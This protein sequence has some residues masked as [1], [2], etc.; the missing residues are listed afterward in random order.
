M[1]N[2]SHRLIIT[3]VL[4]LLLL[5]GCNAAPTPT[6]EP[7]EPASRFMDF[8]GLTWGMTPDEAIRALE[9]T[10]AQQANSDSLVLHNIRMT[11]FGAENADVYLY[12]GDRNGDGI[13]TLHQVLAVLPYS[14][15]IDAMARQIEAH[16]GIAPELTE[17]EQTDYA[18]NPMTAKLWKWQSEAVHQDIASAY[19]IETILALD[20][21]YHSMLTD[22]VTYII[23]NNDDIRDHTLDGMHTKNVLTMT[24][25]ISFYQFEGGYSTQ[26]E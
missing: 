4:S 11:V 10:D 20:E 9:L 23:L 21:Q 13:H 6:T 17:K 2:G 14:T 3:L 16:Y 1:K 7:T 19:D 18:G 24:S 5:V 8:P 22:P 15:D 26:A 25:K 12:F